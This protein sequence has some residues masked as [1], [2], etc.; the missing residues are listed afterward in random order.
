MLQVTYT[1]ANAASV[2]FSRPARTCTCTAQ[3]VV[4]KYAVAYM[5]VTRKPPVL[6]RAAAAAADGGGDGGDICRAV[7]APPGDCHRIV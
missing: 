2:R 4:N 6:A 3:M 1:V 5:Y 7:I